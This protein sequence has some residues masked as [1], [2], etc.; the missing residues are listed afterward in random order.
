MDV[1]GGTFGERRGEFDIALAILRAAN[2]GE[3]RTRIMYA[4]NVSH[5]MLRRYLDGLLALGFVER[6][7][8]AYGL[9]P[10]GLAL[11]RDMERVVTH[12]RAIPA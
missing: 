4:A 2:S 12:F 10:K 3:G 8:Q 11:L 6:R 5:A 9:T 1:L 7:G